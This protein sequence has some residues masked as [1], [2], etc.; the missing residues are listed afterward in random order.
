MG[1]NLSQGSRRVPLGMMKTEYTIFTLD[2]KCVLLSSKLTRSYS[3]KIPQSLHLHALT[4][5]SYRGTDK[6]LARP[7]SRCILFEGE[8]ISFDASIVIYK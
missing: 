5:F 3:T 4:L 2:M 6:F 7:T 8:N 1:K